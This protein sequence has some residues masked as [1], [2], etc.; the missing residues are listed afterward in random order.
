MKNFFRIVYF[1]LL[2]VN[3]DFLFAQKQKNKA[4]NKTYTYKK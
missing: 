3:T 2:L 1:C 4:I